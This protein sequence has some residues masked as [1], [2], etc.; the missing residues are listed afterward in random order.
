MTPTRAHGLSEVLTQRKLHGI[1]LMSGAIFLFAVVDVL[2]KL[3]AAAYPAN[4]ITFFRMLFGLLPAMLMFR[5]CSVQKKALNAERLLGH[6]VRALMAL[7]S[8]GLFFAGLPYLPLSS[9]VALQY[10]EAIFIGL[11]AVPFLKERFR[12]VSVATLFLGFFGVVLIS[13]FS[14]GEASAFGTTLILLSAVFGAGSVIQIKRLSKGEEPATIVLYFT[15]I[16]TV[17]SGLS[18]FF[19]WVPPDSKDLMY[20]VFIGIAAGTGQLL[21]TFAFRNATASLLAPFGY[22]GI[23]WAVIFGYFIWGETVSLHAALGIALIIISTVFL[24]ITDRRID[25]GDASA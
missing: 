12:A 2:A 18:L 19:S 17:I 25:Y 1:I 24:G 4:E 14:G 11:L 13:S 6:G 16:A 3:V 20:M 15:L 5:F 22:F 23:V 10:T 8:M 21:L 9:A 7:G